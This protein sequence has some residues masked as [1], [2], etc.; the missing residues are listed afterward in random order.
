[1]EY[2]QDVHGL[3]CPK[4]KHGMDEVTYEEVTIDRCSNCHGLW[5]D[6]DEAHQLKLKGVSKVVDT[7]DPKKGWI[8]DSHSDICCPRC[9]KE[10]LKSA[11]PDQ[12]HIW[13]ELCEEHGM[14]MDAGEYTDF[15]DESLL[16]RFRALIKGNREITAP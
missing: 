3:Q 6:G 2:N 13:I 7:G 4:C 8:W 10:M 5:F 14:F 11:D 15:E 12:K 16:D 1:M 9:N